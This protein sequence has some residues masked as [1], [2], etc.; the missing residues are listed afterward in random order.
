[1][2]MRAACIMVGAV[3]TLTSPAAA[4]TC[5][6]GRS[7]HPHLGVRIFHCR[8]GSCLVAGAVATTE[9]RRRGGL[10]QE[11]RYPDVLTAA[12]RRHPRAFYFTVE[13]Y[14]WGI[15]RNGP[16]AGRVEEGD[17]LVAVE[18]DPITS[19]AGS[20]HLTRMEAGRPLD[21][22]LRRD[23]RLVEKTVVPVSTCARYTAS[24]GPSERP[25]SMEV[26]TNAYERTVANRA[27]ADGQRSTTTSTTLE[28]VFVGS[29]ETQVDSTGEVAWRFLEPPTVVRADEGGPGHRA[30]LRV[31]DRVTA[32][33]GIPVT[34][35]EGSAAL[36]TAGHGRSTSVTV[37]RGAEDRTIDIVVAER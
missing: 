26:R 6:S 32:V 34:R 14:L 13:P 11:V 21:L 16:A 24:A 7:P 15:D 23:G 30:G 33:D 35:S 25:H 18:G 29:K 28:V 36:V 17:V 27:A 2:K 22:A 12:K 31:G 10:G 3:M 5:E 9:A 4:Q 37:Q 19:A 20:R 8:G 1:M